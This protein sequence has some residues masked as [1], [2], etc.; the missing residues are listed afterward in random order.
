M[1]FPGQLVQTQVLC[2]E[3]GKP[4]TNRTPPGSAFLMVFC[5]D[6]GCS[7]ALLLI[8]KSTAMVIW[9]SAIGTYDGE[10]WIPGFPM[11]ADKEGLQLWPADPDGK[12]RFVPKYM[13]EKNCKICGMEESYPRHSLRKM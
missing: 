4:M 5:G 2:P 10:K 11:L 8:E 12:H 7:G 1:I 13:D 3:C 6:T 9:T